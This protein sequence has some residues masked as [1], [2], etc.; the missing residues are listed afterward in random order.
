MNELLTNSNISLTDFQHDNVDVVRA[1]AA[2]IMDLIEEW[3]M[4]L[5][6]CLGGDPVTGKGL[7]NEKGSSLWRSSDE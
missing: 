7:L 1:E 4:F 5:P 3:Q 6:H 2:R